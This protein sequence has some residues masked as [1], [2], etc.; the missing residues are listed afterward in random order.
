MSM[1]GKPNGHVV[2]LPVDTASAPKAP[3]PPR[4]RGAHGLVVTLMAAF[5]FLGIGALFAFI[6]VEWPGE[7][8]RYVMAV[9][10]FSVVGFIACA[11]IAVFTAAR[12]MAGAPQR[13]DD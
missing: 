6:T 9:F 12:G 8:S 5:A 4:H 7:S 13:R 1:D 2:P 11:S 10:M 3:P